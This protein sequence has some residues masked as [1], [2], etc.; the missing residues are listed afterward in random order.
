MIIGV[1]APVLVSALVSSSPTDGLGRTDEQGLVYPAYETVS[2][3]QSYGVSSTVIYL[4]P[5]NRVHGVWRAGMH[6]MGA[7][8]RNKSLA[9]PA[10]SQST[11]CTAPR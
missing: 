7:Q 1:H 2:A 5:S 6:V 3:A 4:G 10:S 11:L 9:A 8:A